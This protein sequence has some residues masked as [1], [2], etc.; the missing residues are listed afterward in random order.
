MSKRKREL[1]D[2]ESES[3]ASSPSSTLQTPS[4]QLSLCELTRACV[5]HSI[6]FLSLQDRAHLSVTCKT[7]NT[8]CQDQASFPPTLALEHA[9]PP[10]HSLDHKR[11]DTIWITAYL[12]HD[13]IISEFSRL[14]K[15]VKVNKLHCWSVLYAAQ[16]CHI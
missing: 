6:S 9:S 15:Y 14:L 12:M 16:S 13:A 2:S 11:I 5:C 10:P 8:W 7:M 1:K 3:H 4:S